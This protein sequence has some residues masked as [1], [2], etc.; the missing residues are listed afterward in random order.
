MSKAIHA[1]ST[2]LNQGNY[3]AIA[4]LFAVPAIL[5]QGPYEWKLVTRKQI[6]RWH[7]LL[8]CAG[9]V[10]AI[11]F[12]G[13]RSALAVFR[14]GTRK[15]F[16]CDAPGSLAAARYT[17]RNGKIVRWEQVPVPKGVGHTGIVA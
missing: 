17:F 7:S 16:T 13:E 10:V 14:L 5:I 2:A 1:W 11:R 4:K 6:A 8:P 15:G 12:R 9:A 3:A